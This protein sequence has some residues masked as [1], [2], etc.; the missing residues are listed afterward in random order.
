MP[1]TPE[2]IREIFERAC[3]NKKSFSKEK[4]DIIVDKLA[5]NGEL[6][7]YYKCSFCSAYHL[8]TQEHSPLEQLEII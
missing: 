3:L 2:K 6:I 8:T 5:F 7:Y 4:A 1:V